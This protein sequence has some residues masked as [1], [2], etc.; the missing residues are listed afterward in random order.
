MIA[1][2]SS[3]VWTRA[4]LQR[5]ANA[6]AEAD[7]APLRLRGVKIIPEDVDLLRSL[8]FRCLLQELVENAAPA[9]T[10]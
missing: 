7:L 5:T 4:Q 9:G 3:N 8:V 2:I 1:V 10:A 6:S